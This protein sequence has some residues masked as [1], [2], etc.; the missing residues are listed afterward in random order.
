GGE[1]CPPGKTAPYL[2]R[3]GRIPGTMGAEYYDL[4]GSG[5]AY[6]DLS[7]TNAGNGIRPNEGVDIRRSRDEGGG[8]D[9]TEPRAREWLQYTVDVEETG[10][11]RI[12][13]RVA[14]GSGGTVRLSLD[15]VDLLGD[16]SFPATGGNATYGNAILGT[17]E[18]PAGRHT[19]RV[20]MRSA[21]F[22]LNRL[23]FDRVSGTSSERDPPGP[24]LE[25][26]ISPNPAR[27]RVEAHVTLPTSTRA[28]VA[29]YDVTGRQVGERVSGWMHAGT[30]DIALDGS[31]LAPG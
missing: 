31:G 25:L 21:G 2:L 28:E 24:T 3:P 10:S 6:F 7:A 4:G 17:A 15:D 27:S 22:S 9:V 20:E 8:H 12:L 29:L 13:A 18:F 1:G 30:H 19:L 14:V 26:S 11:Y 5:V 23:R 16:V